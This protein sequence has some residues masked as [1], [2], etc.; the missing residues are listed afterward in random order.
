MRLLQHRPDSW[1]RSV[2]TR[3]T[4]QQ[5]SY[6]G[7]LPTTMRVCIVVAAVIVPNKAGVVAIVGLKLVLCTDAKCRGNSVRPR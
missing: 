1:L 7:S 5:V 2:V 6:F 4:I 3:P